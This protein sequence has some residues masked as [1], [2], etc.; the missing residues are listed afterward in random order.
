VRKFLLA[1]LVLLVVLA[2]FPL[3]AWLEARRMPVVRS[4]TIHLPRWPAGAAPVKAVLISDIHIGTSAMDVHRLDRIVDQINMIH[5][6]IVLIAG[7]FIAG[8]QPDNA[9]RYGGAMVVPL[10]RLRPPLGVVATLG[11]HDN[12]TEVGLVRR[13]LAAAHVLVLENE[14]VELGPLAIGGLGDRTTG[15]D[16]IARTWRAVA[17]LP[18]APVLLTHAP[19]L[20]PNLPAKA[21]L[22]LAGH[23]HCG[24]VI[25]P[26]YGPVSDDTRYTDYR[27]GIH[28][29]ARRAVLVT[30]GLGTSIIPLRLGAPPDLWVLTL[31]P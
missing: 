18:G 11:N 30:A 19:D 24:Q 6:D 1:L 4:A 14:A 10:S 13:Q 9:A 27:C 8:H 7:D 17:A 22:L 16:K 31:G 3:Y 26:F 5:P 15:H 2:S 29:E 12:W 23:T 28:R 21:P 20:A 25:L